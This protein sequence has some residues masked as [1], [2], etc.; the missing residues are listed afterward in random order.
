MTYVVRFSDPR[1][2]DRVLTGGKGANL[3]KL[4]QAGFP[5]PPG[6]VI[7]PAAYRE[8][9]LSIAGLVDVLR[10]LVPNDHAALVRASAP[11]IDALRGAVM[12]RALEREVASSCAALD[13]SA[14]WAV[15]SSGTAED[16]EGA[17][18]AGQHDTFLNCVGVDEVLRR[19]RDCWCSL[20][21]PR[22]IAYRVRMGI[23]HA[24]VAM[25]V[26]VQRM[27]EADAAGV[28]FTIDPVSGRLDDV[29]IDANFGL[30]ESVVSGEGDVDH[31]VVDR[32]S[33]TISSAE[34]A[35]KTTRIV[36]GASGTRELHVDGA[37]ATHAALTDAQAIAIARL[38]VEI[39][40]HFGWPQD[41]EWALAKGVPVL[42]QSRPITTI[43]PRWTRDESAERFPNVVTPL[44][45]DFVEEGFH[46]SLN[47]SFALM[48]L[49]AYGGKWFASF[50][51][52][53]YGN[54][55]AVELYARRAPV[56][57]LPVAELVRRLPAIVERFR[58]IAE[59][60]PCWR[61]ELPSF[62]REIDGFLAEPVERYDLTALWSYLERVNAAGTR[63][64]LPN[65][66][67]SIGHGVLHRALR[68]LVTATTGETQAEESCVALMACETMT[69]RVNRELR[70]LATLA[71][72]EGLAE[73]LGAGTSEELWRQGESSASPFWKALRGFVA[74]H[75]HRETDF[76][77][78]HPTWAES[79]WV[80]L[81]HVRALLGVTSLEEPCG[82]GADRVDALQLRVI[83]ALP[84]EMRGLAARV[85]ALAREYTALD[86]LEHYHTTRLSLPLR[87]GV[88]EIGRR[89]H[90]LGIVE[91][92]L[93]AFF[94]R[95]ASLRDAIADHTRLD[96]LGA[97]IRG[98]KREYLRA[99]ETAPRWSL[100]AEADG[101]PASR[102]DEHSLNG[103][104]GS[105]GE[106]EG[107]VHI[108]RGTGD[109]ADFPRGAVLVARTTNPAW[110]PLFYSAAA[111]VTESGGPLSH[112]AVTAREMRIPAVMAVRDV[113]VRLR[114]G[115]RVRVNGASGR[116]EVVSAA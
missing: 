71:R 46:R 70:V 112:G 104:P 29:V 80:V 59:L 41:I 74:L 10:D 114:N 11:I 40:E 13:A 93:D 89:L 4:T 52:Y 68:A 87:R 69:T 35:A 115:D 100:A 105:P 50:G 62:L 58:W 88:R 8:A 21:S 37:A 22:A 97:E 101:E 15:R 60:P 85:I 36:A 79:P 47:H 34:I 63:Y 66:A 14:R 76:D 107:V 2:T 1:A 49:P 91:E 102:A 110:T 54:Q 108:V 90:A 53:I 31:F 55:N 16:M 48:G 12:P 103:I 23:A 51:H 81:D 106:A 61:E 27:V 43:P 3:A 38:A 94:A 75:G 26:V 30:G 78:Y 113:L 64:F 5:V 24:Q 44:T 6:F 86:D 45:W 25:A 96:A 92:E 77:A 39:E 56:P 42:L 32:R 65:I 19:V 83:Q 109:F 7:S 20:W 98:T 72:A 33:W 57:S 84:V 73:D 95:A 9:A 116:I 18:F 28:A 67:I 17:A 99:R 82:R 111:V